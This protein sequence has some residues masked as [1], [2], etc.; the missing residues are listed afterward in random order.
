[1]EKEKAKWTLEWE[2]L[3]S[4]ISE[5]KEKVEKVESEKEKYKWD[6]EKHKKVR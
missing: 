1:M 2:R 3:N 5:F 4:A 6:V